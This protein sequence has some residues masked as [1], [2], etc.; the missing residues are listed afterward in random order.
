VGKSHE[1]GE[2]P[3]RLTARRNNAGLHTIYIEGEKKNGQDAVLK[4][5]IYTASPPCRCRKLPMKRRPIRKDSGKADGDCGK[6]AADSRSNQEKKK[7]RQ[8]ASSMS[9]YKGKKKK[10]KK[11]DGR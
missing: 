5:V 9:G 10:E 6:R 4:K 3:T 2:A 11:G 8:R 7:A 1:A